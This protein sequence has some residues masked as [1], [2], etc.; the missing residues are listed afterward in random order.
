MKR[1][2]AWLLPC[3][4]APAF[5]HVPAVAPGGGG[6]TALVACLIVTVALL[7][8]FGLTRL[9][10][11]THE[12]RALLGRA[13][14]FAGGCAA[15][16]LLL[17]G[18]IDGAAPRSFAVHML[19]HEGLMLIA[20]PLL[21]IAKPMPLFLWSLP[22]E[23]RLAVA[24]VLQSNGLKL[25]WHWLTAPLTAWLVHALAL[26]LWHAPSLFNAALQDPVLHEWQ[27]VT[28]LLSA[29]LFWHAVLRRGTHGAQGMALLYLFT[30]T[31]HTGVLGA[32]LTFARQPLYASM[33][34]GLTPWLGLT[35][36]EDQQL[37][38]LIMWVPGALVYV[39]AGLWL[40][41]RWVG[42][43]HSLAR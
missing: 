30:T 27:H 20:A 31:V 28:F 40:L 10:T 19:Q 38:G 23:P 2:L 17:L 22:H 25:G 4:A 12:H 18:P 13:V 15:L 36:L 21:V 1:A 32:L 11:H 33:E 35:P 3:L 29:L 8:G 14:A 41:S 7:Y 26:W 42:P 39:G 24:R 16:A 43:E 37:G 34:Q 9:W 5:A 6:G